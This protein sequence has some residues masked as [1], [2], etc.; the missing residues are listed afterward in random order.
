MKNKRIK[1]AVNE[2]ILLSHA[3]F[4]SASSTQVVTQGQQWQALKILNIYQTPD[5]NLPGRGQAVKAAVQNDTLFNNNGFTRPSSFPKVVIGNLHLERNKGRRSPIET[6]GDDKVCETL[7]DN[8][9][10]TN[11]AS[12]FT[13]IELL[14]VVLIIGILAAVALPQYQLAVEKSR[15]TEALNVLKTMSAAQEVYYLANNEYATQAVSLDIDIPESKF[16]DYSLGP[17]SSGATKKDGSYLLAV[18]YDNNQSKNWAK[19]ACGCNGKSK[20][21]YAR[22]I[23]KLLGADITKNES[24]DNEPRWPFR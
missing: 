7:G 16:F 24:D 19:W 17:M 20:V 12:G 5:K 15:A 4:I 10:M 21:D 11:T 6:L 2:I 3:E 23:C 22:K 18:R 14:V 1:R 13:L 9:S 8:Y